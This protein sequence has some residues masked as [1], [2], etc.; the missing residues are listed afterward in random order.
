MNTRVCAVSSVHHAETPRGSID[1]TIVKPPL[2]IITFDIVVLSFP[3]FIRQ[4]YSKRS[5]KLEQALK[6][7]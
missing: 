3:S 1:Q 5:G 6:A 4:P 2:P 7:A